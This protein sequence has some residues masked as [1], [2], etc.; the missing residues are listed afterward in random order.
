M[1]GRLQFILVNVRLKLSSNS[2]ILYLI[3]CLSYKRFHNLNHLG[4]TGH[5]QAHHPP[6]RVSL[7]R[8][9][10]RI[11]GD[12]PNLDQCRRPPRLAAR[13]FVDILGQ[14]GLTLRARKWR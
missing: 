13:K 14:K 6:V 4:N 9:V 2:G 7:R 3:A 8:I 10:R 11:H 5:G 12:R 1:T